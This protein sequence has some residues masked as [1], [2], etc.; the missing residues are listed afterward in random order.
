MD[1]ETAE[2][3][4]IGDRETNQDRHG[5]LMSDE[6][7]ML[8]VCDGMGGHEDGEL[9]AATAVDCFMA[10]FKEDK[11]KAADAASF[12]RKVIEQGHEETVRVGIKKPID[13]RPRTTATLCIISRG[14]ARWGHVGDSRIYQFR[15]GELVTRTRDHSAVEAMF[16]RGAITEAEMLTHP[17]RNFVEQ[18]LGGEPDQP[19]IEI[20]DA[21]ELEPG[22]VLLLCSDGFWTPLDIGK[23]GE[24]LCAAEDL[25]DALDALAEEAY[26]LAKPQSDNITATAF[27]YEG[28][29]DEED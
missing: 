2:V 24:Q 26:E 1:F 19:K 5:V 25:Q 28:P 3:T 27:R 20:A 18:C 13:Q 10:G 12:I 17:M 29:D 4:L 22:D 14:I 21:V 9:A 15:D 16:Q 7:V 8:T 23:T 11:P 6:E